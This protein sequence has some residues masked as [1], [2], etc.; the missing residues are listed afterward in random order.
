MWC[1]A[2]C[3]RVVARALDDESQVAQP[4]CEADVVGGVGGA[5]QRLRLARRRDGVREASLTPEPEGE[6]A[7]A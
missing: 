4:L 2:G 7:R 1:M 6:S 5:G 3:G